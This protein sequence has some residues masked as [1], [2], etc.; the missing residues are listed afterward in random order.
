MSDAQIKRRLKPVFDR[1]DT[2]GD[3]NISWATFSEW[4]RNNNLF[5]IP[6]NILKFKNDNTIS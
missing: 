5:E 1:L 4:K 3:G 2:D 6:P